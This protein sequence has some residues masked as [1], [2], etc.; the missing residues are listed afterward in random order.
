MSISMPSANWL[1]EHERKEPIT[2]T[3]AAL[4]GRRYRGLPP[5]APQRAFLR[6]MRVRLAYLTNAAYHILFVFLTD[7]FVPFVAFSL[8]AR[9]SVPYSVSAATIT[10]LVGKPL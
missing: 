8:Q 10:G 7:S 1:N 6:T 2:I 4:G 9:Y 3:P 5:D